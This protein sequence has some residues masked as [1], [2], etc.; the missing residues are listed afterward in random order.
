MKILQISIITVL[1][2]VVITGSQ[3]SFG[4]ELPSTNLSNVAPVNGTNTSV[5]YDITSGKLLS[6]NADAQSKSLII[7]VQSTDD[8]KFTISIPRSLLDARENGQSTHFLVLMD[9]RGINYNEIET[10]MNR[11]L[12]IPLHQGTEKFQII[13]TGPY[14]LGFSSSSNREVLEAPFSNN[15]PIIDG[16]WTNSNEWNKTKAVTVEGDG[17]K[18]YIIAQHDMNFLYVIADMVTDQTT[19]SYA[20]LLGYDLFMIFDTNNY[21]GTTLGNNEIGV[22]TS[23]TF[24]NG[25]EVKTGFGSEVWTYDN[26]SKPVDLTSPSNYNSSMEFSSTNDPFESIHDHRIYEF[27]I[28]MSLLHNSDKYG[29]SLKAAAC[30]GQDAAVCRPI[31]TLFWPSGTIMSVPSSHGILK[32]DNATA[33]TSSAVTIPNNFELIIVGIVV[34]GV[35]GIAGFFYYKNFE[36]KK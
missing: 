9:N 14:T 36:T 30:S 10:T 32:L 22:G 31:Y 20:P 34:G 3:T 25:T 6:I 35:G 7:L 28:P 33:T 8:G 16:K 4:Q 13:G 11:I 15:S 17:T 24:I 29:F 12:E 1:L 19:P 26:Q 21:Q 5:N 18:M 23:H 2:I 27:R